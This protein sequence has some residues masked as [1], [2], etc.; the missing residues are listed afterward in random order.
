MINLDTWLDATDP[1]EGAK[2][3]L[4]YASRVSDNGLITGYG[5][6]DDGVGGMS[7]GTRAFILD[8]STLIPESSSPLPLATADVFYSATLAASGGTAPFTWVLSSGSLPAGLTCS[9][10]GVISGTALSPTNVSFI[11]Q[12]T[13]HAG[14]VLSKTFSLKIV[15]LADAVDQLSVD[16]TTSAPRTWFAQTNTTHDGRDA[17]QSGAITNS[18][19]SEM[20]TTVTGPGT[21]SF[22]W[23]VSSESGFDSLLFYVDG[24]TERASISGTTDWQKVTYTLTAG[25][26]VMRWVYAKDSTL[27][28][29]SDG[30]WVDQLTVPL[31]PTIMTSSPLPSGT[32]DTVY[33]KALVASGNVPPFTWDI[34]AGSLPIGLSLSSAGLISGTPSMATNASFTVRVTDFNGLFSTKD[35]GLTISAPA[36][37][38]VTF[39]LG[40]Q[41]TWSGSGD[42]IQQVVSGG[43]ATAPTITTAAG[44]TFTGWD[45]SFSSI[46]YDLTVTALY[47]NPDSDNDGLPDEWETLYFASLTE[48]DGSGDFDIDGIS[49]GDEYICGTQP[50]NPDS[51]LRAE[52]SITANGFVVSWN[53]VEGRFYD[54]LWASS[55]TNS[56]QSLTTGLAYPQNSYTDT[57]HAAESVGFYRVTAAMAPV[58]MVSIPVGTNSGTDPDFGAYSLTVSNAFYMDATEVTKE[59]W[60]TVY[61]WALS[62]GYQFDNIGSSKAANHPVQTVSWYDCVKWC[63]ARSEMV[64]K[65]PCY[66]V[67]GNLYKTGQSDPDCNINANGYRL[68]T[69]TEWEYAARGGLNGKRFPWGDTITHSDA[70]FWSW[71]LNSYDISPTRGHHPTYETGEMPYTSPVGSFAA[72]GYGLFDMAG[73]IF[74]W[75]WDMADANRTILGGGWHWDSSVARCSSV[76]PSHPSFSGFELGFRTLCRKGTSPSI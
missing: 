44:W 65:T 25:S 74:E 21:V 18:Q 64:G 37:Y 72:N 11:A 60:D 26:H 73:N 34:S 57:V 63:N 41:G 13:D 47:F 51:V 69:R 55:L 36:S 1:T 76:S 35:F 8:A 12:R 9:S 43:D 58:G 31:P 3:T 24:I 4:Y 33:E 7:D 40:T 38:T 56:F 27:S 70:N 66:T 75:C 19:T 17:A 67:I 30:G 14:L 61:T 68:P 32:V 10:S 6:Y 50:N 22:W 45:Q 15:T 46:F 49:D 20:Q 42:L 48:S 29:G 28:S 59:Q 52:F 62:H 71:E 53:S 5:L 23:K 39:D 16:V 54:V 2:W